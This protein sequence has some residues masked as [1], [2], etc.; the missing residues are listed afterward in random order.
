MADIVKLGTRGEIV[1][2]R[3]MLADLGV[4]EGDDLT[5]ELDG[6]AIV[7]RRKARRFAEY[8]EKVGRR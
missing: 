8:L 1:L 4:Q 5:V 2:P 3:K 6:Q 7:V